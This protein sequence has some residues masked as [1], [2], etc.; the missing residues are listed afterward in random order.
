MLGLQPLE[1]QVL[2]FGPHVLHAHAPGERGIDVHRLLGDALALVG[3]HELEGAHVVQAVGELDEQDAYVG[4]NGKEELAQIFRLRFLARDEVQPLDLGEAV[5]DGADLGAEQ[6][7]DLGPRGVGVL[8][9]VVQQ[10][11]R[12]GGVIELEVG[13]DR[14][15]FERVGEVGVAR[16]A[17]LTAMLLHGVDVGLVEQLLVGVGVIRLH[18]LNEFELTHHGFTNIN[19][20]ATPAA[21]WRDPSR[22]GKRRRTA[23]PTPHDI[24]I[25]GSD[26]IRRHIELCFDRQIPRM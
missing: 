18:A 5:D 23:C 4:R 19:L 21:G 14:G 3:R 15:H 24:V 25:I 17:H 13:E 16:G 10:R 20:A 1:R 22:H 9:G 12:N 6:L 11:D 7:V 2:Q 8:N 26:A